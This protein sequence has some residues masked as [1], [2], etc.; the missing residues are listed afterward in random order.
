MPFPHSIYLGAGGVAE[1]SRTNSVQWST[2]RDRV[3]ATFVHMC[4]CFW[5]LITEEVITPATQVRSS[6]WSAQSQYLSG[7]AIC[8]LGLARVDRLLQSTHFLRVGRPKSISS[9]TILGHRQH[10]PPRTPQNF[11]FFRSATRKVVGH[12]RAMVP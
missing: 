1:I 7:H 3:I 2:P 11:F 5:T 8:Q 12:T 9:D 4:M 10:F 6:T